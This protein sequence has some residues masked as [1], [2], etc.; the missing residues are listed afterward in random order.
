VGLFWLTADIAAWDAERQREEAAGYPQKR[1]DEIRTAQE[2]MRREH[3]GILF[4]T[5]QYELRTEPSHS[6][7]ASDK[8]M[9]EHTKAAVDLER[10]CCMEIVLTWDAVGGTWNGVEPQSAETIQRT[11]MGLI[12]RG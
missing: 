3:A 5:E 4:A 2:A 6:E 11:I 12:A 9:L 7:G 8:M 10:R 1:I